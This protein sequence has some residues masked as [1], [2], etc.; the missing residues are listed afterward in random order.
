MISQK[1]LK[2]LVDVFNEKIE[3]FSSNIPLISRFCCKNFNRSPLVIRKMLVLRKIQIS[4]KYAVD[5]VECP[6]PHSQKVLEV[7]MN[8]EFYVTGKF[9]WLQNSV[10]S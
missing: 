7:L 6:G 4:L 8:I 3:I 9:C 1:N 5:N 10:I 2:Y